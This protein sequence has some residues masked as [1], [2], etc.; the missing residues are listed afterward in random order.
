LAAPSLEDKQETCILGQS[1]VEHLVGELP[2]GKEEVEICPAIT[3]DL[4]V[5]FL[6]QQ[7][8]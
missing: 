6:Q 7:N 3:L 1:R 5:T 2:I 4:H 8:V